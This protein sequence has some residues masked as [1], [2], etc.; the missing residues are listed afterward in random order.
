M[1]RLLALLVVLALAAAGGSFA[2]SQ[3]DR[4]ASTQR[5]PSP[6]P[7]TLTEGRFIAGSATLVSSYAAVSSVRR[8]AG[9]VTARGKV[10]IVVLCYAGTVHLTLGSLTNSGPCKG[11]PDAALALPLTQDL[12][13]TATVS[14]PQGKAW[15]FAIY[16]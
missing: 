7:A 9:T 16:R 11:K 1:R 13:I 14:V 8:T 4:G 2:L 6:F 10:Y 12:P 3:R 15:G 5:L